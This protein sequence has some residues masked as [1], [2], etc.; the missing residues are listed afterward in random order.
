MTKADDRKKE[1]EHR[2]ESTPTAASPSSGIG[3]GTQIGH[4]CI[5]HELGRGG[6]GVVYLARDTK[7]DRPVAIR[8]PPPEVTDNP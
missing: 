1:P 8:S 6:V 2:E 5:D 3:P 7:L 4:F